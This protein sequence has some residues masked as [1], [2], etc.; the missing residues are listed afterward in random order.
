MKTNIFFFIGIQLI[1]FA[2]TIYAIVW[3]V[4]SFSTENVSCIVNHIWLETRM[5]S[6]DV[7]VLINVQVMDHPEIGD[8]ELYVYKH[9]EN[10]YKAQALMNAYALNVSY[11]CTIRPSYTTLTEFAHIKIGVWHEAGMSMGILATI[12]LGIIVIMFVGSLMMTVGEERANERIKDLEY[13]LLQTK[14]SDYEKPV[15]TQSS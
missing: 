12:V 11:P 13:Q 5:Y 6:Y 7:S 14:S 8:T 1:I 2:A 4:N 3:Q 15:E 10:P 9:K